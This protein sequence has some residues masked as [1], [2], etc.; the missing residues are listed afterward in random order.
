MRVAAE[1]K[2]DSCYNQAEKRTAE[3]PA[4]LLLYHSAVCVWM[5]ENSFPQG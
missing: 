2:N 3:L 1:E 5:L 4:V